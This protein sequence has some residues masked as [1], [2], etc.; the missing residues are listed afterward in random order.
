MTPRRFA[1]LAAALCGTVFLAGWVIAEVAGLGMQ[2]IKNTYKG[3]TEDRR[4][5]PLGADADPVDAPKA[6]AVG[7]V[8]IANVD[9][10]TAAAETGTRGSGEAEA[11]EGALPDPSQMPPPKTPPVQLATASTPAQRKM[12]D[13]TSGTAAAVPRTVKDKSFD[14][15]IIAKTIGDEASRLKNDAIEWGQKLQELEANLKSS[16]NVDGTAKDVDGCLVVLQAAAGRL[17]PNSETR[18]LCGSRR[19]PFET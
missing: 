16:Q 8:G 10:G 12:I 3:L 18:P 4:A 15:S 14:P 11:V 5:P 17:T 13:K 19:M 9:A 7:K 2:G 6:T 1:T